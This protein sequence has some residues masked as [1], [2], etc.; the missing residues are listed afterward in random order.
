MVTFFEGEDFRPCRTR[1][2]G[3][4]MASS[5]WLPLCTELWTLPSCNVRLVESF[6]HCSW[7]ALIKRVTPVELQAFALL[8]PIRLAIRLLLVHQKS[9]RANVN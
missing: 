8:L 4:G 2:R 6:V 1:R 7:K 3:I 9:A 5:A